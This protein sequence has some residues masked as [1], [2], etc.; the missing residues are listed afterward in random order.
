M[1]PEI[2][3]FRSFRFYLDNSHMIWKKYHLL[4]F[5]YIIVYVK[6]VPNGL[7][8]PF[9][10]ASSFFLPWRKFSNWNFFHH[11]Y[12]FT[13]YSEIKLKPM[14]YG[15]AFFESCDEKN[16][17]PSKKSLTIVKNPNE[18]C[19]LPGARWLFLTA[20]INFPN[21][22]VGG[23]ASYFFFLIWSKRKIEDN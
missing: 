8:K 19:K 16:E 4:L 2:C 22:H 23:K 13:G 15:K 10:I 6:Y 21:H 11:L 7:T 17:I 1:A 12:D 14:V 18:T 9:S 20:C 3:I 5:T